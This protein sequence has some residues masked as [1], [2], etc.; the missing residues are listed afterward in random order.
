MAKARV[1][2]VL[3]TSLLVV[4]VVFFILKNIKKFNASGG[5]AGQLPAFGGGQNH[6]H[7]TRRRFLGRGVVV[8]VVEISPVLTYIKH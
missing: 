7:Q 5:P 6:P 1:V 2:E 4:Q 3:L 8:V